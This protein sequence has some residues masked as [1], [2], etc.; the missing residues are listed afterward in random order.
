MT[1][2][3]LALTLMAAGTATSV[4]GGIK[5]GNAAKRAGE[6]GQRAADSQ[7]ELADYNANVATLQ[8]DDAIARGVEE[9]QRFR[10]KVRASIGAQRVGFAAGNIDVSS[11]S[12]ADVQAD[13]AYLGELDA[14]TISGNAA[15]EAWGY[16]TQAE[17]LTR[18]GQIARQEGAAMAEAGRVNQTASRWNAASSLVTASS[19][20]LG[21]KYGFGGRR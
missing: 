5:S 7:G 19:T 11:G 2:T 12:A 6:A 1:M 4:I 10:T 9:E 8:A 3:A 20:L 18:R 15:R 14:L 21:A 16:K 17:D 13:A